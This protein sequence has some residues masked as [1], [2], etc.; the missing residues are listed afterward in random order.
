MKNHIYD[1]SWEKR[2]NVTYDNSYR[3]DAKQ[4]RK[5][6]RREGLQRL[7][8]TIAHFDKCVE[9]D[10]CR[11]LRKNILPLIINDNVKKGYLSKEQEQ[12]FLSQLNSP[13]SENWYMA[14]V[15]INQLLNL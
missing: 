5:Y 3:Y 7:K 15:M 2:K 12:T 6:F 14:F 11:V 9:L 13:D 10:D 8:E 1:H 4:E